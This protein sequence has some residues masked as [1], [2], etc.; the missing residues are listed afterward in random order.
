MF[1]VRTISD[2]NYIKRAVLRPD[3]ADFPQSVDV[4]AAKP[5]VLGRELP[6]LMEVVEKEAHFPVQE[7]VEGGNVALIGA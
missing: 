3:H 5:H 4:Y 7:H 1:G 2:R 6:I